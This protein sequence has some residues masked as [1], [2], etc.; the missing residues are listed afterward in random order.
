MRRATLLASGLALALTAGG[1]AQQSKPAGPPPGRLLN[2]GGRSLHLRCVG[3][4]TGRPTV[5][6]EAGAGDY[7]DRWIGVQDLLAP[8]VRSCAY[9]RAGFGWS[10]GTEQSMSQD[11]ADLRALLTA[12]N[13]D[14]PYVLVGHSMGALL[15]RRY[16]NQYPD[17]VVGMVLVGPTHENTYLFSVRDKQWKRMR[18]LPIGTDF[19]EVYLARQAD[20]VP[21][22]DRPLIVVVGTRATEPGASMPEDVAREKAAED[23][24]HSRISRNSKLVRDPSSGHHIHVENPKIVADAIE[25]VVSAAMKGTKLAATR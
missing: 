25:D 3:P 2:V 16:A 1:S 11:N 12:A 4:A 19:Q 7:S 15:V 6:L 22:G 18:E 13:V 21:L 8:R 23:E 5:I 14:G 20:P 9:D 24:D 17:G 10:D